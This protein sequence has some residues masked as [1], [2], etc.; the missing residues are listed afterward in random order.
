MNY[1]NGSARGH[2]KPTLTGGA[3]ETVLSLEM[4]R[5]GLRLCVR[6]P[7]TLSRRSQDRHGRSAVARSLL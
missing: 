7:A 2:V 4:T 1:T 5:R 6:K 3:M